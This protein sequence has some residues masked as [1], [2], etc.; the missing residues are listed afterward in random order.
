MV[1]MIVIMYWMFIYEDPYH[2]ITSNI[3]IKEQLKTLNPYI[4]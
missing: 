3:I 1:T 4:L 2:R